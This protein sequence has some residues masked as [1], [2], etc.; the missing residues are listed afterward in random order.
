MRE[1][2]NRK[3]NI[4]VYLLIYTIGFVTLYYVCY[5]Q[6]FFKYNKAL[7]RSYDGLNQH[8]LIF[9]YIGKLGRQI[10][11]SL[12]IDHKL[13]IPLWNMGIG[14]GADVFTSIGAYLPDPFNWISVFIPTRYSEIGYS[15]SIILK[16]YLSGLAFSFF[17]A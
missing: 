4:I 17:A 14:Y 9:I 7:F 10:I 6:W 15:F 2:W 5:G 13:S 11:K 16:L 3:K 12:L 1:I 8:Y